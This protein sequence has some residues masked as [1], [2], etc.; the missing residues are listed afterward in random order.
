MDK[1]LVKLLFGCFAI[2]LFVFAGCSPKEDVVEDD[3]VNESLIETDDVSLKNLCAVNNGTWIEEVQECEYVS[4]EFCDENGGVFYECGSACRNNPDA[5]ICTAQCV[6]FCSF[7]EEKDESSGNVR[8]CTMEYAPVCGVDG[9]TYSN[10]CMADEVEV[11][12]VGECGQDN[13]FREPKKCTKEYMPVC[14]VD[15]VTYSNECLA[16]DMTIEHQGECDTYQ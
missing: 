13:A 12:Y 11:A 16:G 6:P 14:G 5:Q 7:S 8:A 15:G 4:E 9:K 2:C 10:E 3:K 1:K